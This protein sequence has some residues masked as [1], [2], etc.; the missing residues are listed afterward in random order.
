MT[1]KQKLFKEYEE[2]YR[3]YEALEREYPAA[4]LGRMVA[5]AHRKSE[6]DTS[7]AM[8]ERCV[9]KKDRAELMDLRWGII[10][11]FSAKELEEMKKNGAA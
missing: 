11:E 9:T 4:S 8:V 6:L 2:M 1:L 10:K 7:M 5:I 3:E